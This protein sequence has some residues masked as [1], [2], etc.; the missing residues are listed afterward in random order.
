MSNIVGVGFGKPYQ[1]VWLG[2]G[3]WVGEQGKFVNMVSN[4]ANTFYKFINVK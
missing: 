2:F 3:K 4:T 1:H